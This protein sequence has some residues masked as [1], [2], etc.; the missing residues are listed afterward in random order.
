[1][2]QDH[3][4]NKSEGMPKD[5]VLNGYDDGVASAGLVDTPG[6]PTSSKTRTQNQWF[7]AKKNV[8]LAGAEDAP[9]NRKISA[10]QQH[11]ILDFVKGTKISKRVVGLVLTKPKVPLKIQNRRAESESNIKTKG[12]QQPSSGTANETQMEKS[13]HQKKVQSVYINV[14]NQPEQDQQ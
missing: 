13:D 14:R 2:I 7:Q 6:Q 4:E 11:K 12:S 8:L 5:G 1:M 9:A 3:K 10:E